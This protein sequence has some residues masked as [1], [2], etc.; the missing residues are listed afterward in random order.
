MICT[1]IAEN[2]NVK[3][4]LHIGN[5]KEN[6]HKNPA[7]NNFANLE[8]VDF[9]TSLGILYYL[10]LF[11]KLEKERLGKKNILQKCMEK[12]H[13]MKYTQLKH[14]FRNKWYFKNTE[15]LEDLL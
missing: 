6:C 2:Y 1:T 4:P 14:T 10:C 11:E 8:F 7:L 13:L 5:K 15:E 9:E 3:Q 12:L